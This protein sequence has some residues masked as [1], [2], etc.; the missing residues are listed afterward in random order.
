MYT[1]EHR[2]NKSVKEGKYYPL[3]ATVTDSGINFAL[4]SQSARE[5]FLLLFDGK[6]DGEPSD[7][8]RLSNRQR[9]I[10][11]AFVEGIGPGQLYGY[12]VR[13]DYAPQSGLRFNEHKLLMDP[14]AKALT[15]K[16][17]NRDNLLLAYNPNS[18]VKDLEMDRRDNTA[19]VPKC[20]VVD[21]AFDWEGDAPLDIPLAD[22]IVYEMHVKGFTKDP[23][24]RAK[25]GGTYLGATEKIPYLKDLGVTAVELLPIH[26]YC[27]EDFLSGRGL[28]NYWGYNTIGFFAPEQS[29]GSQSYPGCQVKEFK[30]LVKSLHAAGIEVILD[31]VFNH[32]AEGNELG[33][34]LCFKG[35][36][37]QSY[38]YLTGDSS[39]PYRYYMNYTGCGNSLNL[40]NVPVIRFVLDSLRY[41]VTVMH[42]DGFRFDLASVLGR[43]HG[44]FYKS[45]SFF[46]AI[47]QNPVLSRVKLIAEPWDLGTYEVGNFPIDWSEWNGKFRDTMRKFVKGDDGQLRD[48]G[49][50]ITGSADLYGDDGRTPYNSINF[51][52]CHDGFTL[53]D[54][55]SYNGKH[56]EANK[57]DN[58]DGTND[59]ASWNCGEEGV[60]TNPDILRLRRQQMKNLSCLLFLSLGTPMITGGDEFGRTQYGNNNGYCQDNGISWFDWT[61]SEKN[62]EMLDFTKKLIA[63][64]KKHPVFRR[65]TF[66]SGADSDMDGVCDVCWFSNT[67]GKPDW[68]SPSERKIAVQ[69]D[70]DENDALGKS[71]CILY[72]MD[73]VINFFTLPK[74]RGKSEWRR[75][76][77]TSLPKGKDFLDEEN[78]EPLSDKE[79]YIV[80]PR[81]TVVLVSV[82][83]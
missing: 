52:T 12:K 34:T 41:W 6:D 48:L 68:D 51:V 32:S 31:V 33:P 27:V 55:V 79:V 23:S 15:H 64:R 65:K 54:L 77:D 69:L 47:S 46:D 20:I 60:T 19:M 78:A 28:T 7:I 5:V 44:T 36:D 13:G 59:N 11:Y 38:Y 81:S 75:L 8:I 10:F 82:K 4:F 63:F 56:N 29:Y 71:I 80:N 9:N 83:Q 16:F 22:S 73:W 62:R 39:A 14:Y 66:F 35:I 72:N 45:S 50:R 58:R 74:L 24:S 18:S 53:Y 26:E 57:E 37:N 49:N 17:V 43:E 61:L 30:T 70:T 42:V 76:A 40:T 3:G 1:L 67:G 25:N 2:T 21:D